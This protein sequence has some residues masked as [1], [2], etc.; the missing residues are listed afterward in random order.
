MISQN[1]INNIKNK[2][3]SSLFIHL[4]LQWY[5]HKYTYIN[6][7][8]FTLIESLSH[9]LDQYRIQLDQKQQ[10]ITSLQVSFYHILESRSMT[11]KINIFNHL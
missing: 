4:F 3:V 1:L 11:N 7:F 10:I 5:K 8:Y 6:L 2:S 9:A